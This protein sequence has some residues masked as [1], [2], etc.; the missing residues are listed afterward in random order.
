[1][2]S[3]TDPNCLLPSDRSREAT[4]ET[5]TRSGRSAVWL[6]SNRGHHV[7]RTPSCAGAAAVAAGEHG[8]PRRPGLTMTTQNLPQPSTKHDRDSS[9]DRF[10]VAVVG[11]GQAGLAIGHRLAE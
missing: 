5:R 1:M 7:Q 10:D 4:W 9:P 6:E 8:P 11:G 2:Q 3:C